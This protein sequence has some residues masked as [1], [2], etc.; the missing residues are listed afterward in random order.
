MHPMLNI[1]NQAALDAGKIILRFMDRLD[2]VKVSKKDRNDLVSEVDKLC[3]QTIIEAIKKG[4]PKHSI[5]AEES[6]LQDT[7]NDY[8]WVIDPLDGTA[9]FVHGFPQFAISIAVK[10]GDQLEVGCVYDPARQELFTATKGKGA[11]LNNRRIRVAN[12]KKL[13]KGLIGTGF[14]FKNKAYLSTY[15][16]GFEKI[17]LDSAGIRR[18][19]AAALDLAYVA[20]GRLD[21]FWEAGLQP[22]D[23]AAG[24]LLIQEAGGIVTDFKGQANY[25]DSGNIVAGNISIHQTLITHLTES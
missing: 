9:N 3:E 22:W 10:K 4:Y 21:G 18:A 11:Q 17:F 1:A 13:Q 15:L 7:D 5:L 2:E 6:G 12:T 19:G 23:M 25:F 24:I 8:C 14:P 20:A 16:K